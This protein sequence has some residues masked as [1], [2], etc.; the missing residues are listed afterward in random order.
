MAS[1]PQPSAITPCLYYEDGIAALDWLAKAFGFRERTRETLEDGRLRHGEMQVGNAVIYV[2]SPPGHQSPRS[3]GQFTIGLYVQVE[4]VDAHYERARS[5]G[6]QVQG[7]PQDQPY[8]DRNYGVLDLEGHQW[9]F[10]QP[11][12]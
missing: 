5:A 12:R 10:A 3:L 7:E 6:A 4:D 2:W 1:T 8:G 9:W 11:V